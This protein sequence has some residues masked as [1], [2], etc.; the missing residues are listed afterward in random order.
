MRSTVTEV[1]SK[2]AMTIEDLK[3]FEILLPTNLLTLRRQRLSH[4]ETRPH[5]TT[6]FCLDDVSNIH[7]FITLLS[8]T[9]DLY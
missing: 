8:Y 1:S 5:K 3:G 9:Y 2:I 4:Q 7:Y 6:I